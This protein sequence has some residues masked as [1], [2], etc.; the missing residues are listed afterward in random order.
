MKGG[1]KVRWFFCFQTRM[2]AGWPVWL[3]GL[4]PRL[5]THTLINPESVCPLEHNLQKSS[6][7]V[8]SVISVKS[9]TS[10]FTQKPELCAFQSCFPYLWYE[11]QILYDEGE[12][13]R[14][15]AGR[16]LSSSYIFSKRTCHPGSRSFPPFLSLSLCL[17]NTIS[18]E[19]ISPSSYVKGL[20]RKRNS[21]QCDA[22]QRRCLHTT[23]FTD[24]PL[25]STCKGS[26]TAQIQANDTRGIQQRLSPTADRAPDSEHQ[27][28]TWMP[29]VSF[30]PSKNPKAKD[31]KKWETVVLQYNDRSDGRTG[32]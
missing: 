6:Q 29:P 31:R 18:Y 13:H 19:N 15:D 24:R 8:N 10:L 4:R 2:H 7:Y 12:K 32:R 25:K 3:W 23:H 30:T 27:P 14:R 22:D 9:I 21:P 5:S 20:P 28:K 1:S 11:I 16:R 26:C 17:L